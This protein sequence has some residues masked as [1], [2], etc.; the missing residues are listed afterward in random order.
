[1][2][3]TA[4]VLRKAAVVVLETEAY[5]DTSLGLSRQASFVSTVI[6]NMAVQCGAFVVGNPDC[7]TASYA[8]FNEVLKII[9]HIK[10]LFGKREKRK[11]N[12]FIKNLDEG[13]RNYQ[14]FILD[15]KYHTPSQAP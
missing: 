7:L 3:H 11:R 5:T 2:N 4:D 14:D 1:M 6:E 10:C 9:P 13:V 12:M 15:N 8:C